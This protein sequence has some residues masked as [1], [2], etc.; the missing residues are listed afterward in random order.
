MKLLSIFKLIAYVP[1][2][3][4]IRLDR[5]TFPQQSLRNQSTTRNDKEQKI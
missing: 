4:G 2:T 3:V 1:F 5:H